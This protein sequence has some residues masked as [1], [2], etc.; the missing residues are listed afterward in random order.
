VSS[1]NIVTKIFIVAWL[2]AQLTIPF[3]RKF[4]LQPFR[5][6]WTPFSWG[7][8]STSEAEYQV[9]MY[10][11]GPDGERSEIVFD[12]D[13]VGGT[14]WSSGLVQGERY[15]V[16]RLQTLREVEIV[17]RRVAR[18]NGD[19]DVYVGS[20]DWHYLDDGRFLSQEIRVRTSP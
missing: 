10:R 8:Y 19:D 14:P 17:L 18:R 12:E 6:R 15:S 4:D 2:T 7:M 9:T 13:V 1:R 16:Q 11:L 3:I 20:I 5:Y